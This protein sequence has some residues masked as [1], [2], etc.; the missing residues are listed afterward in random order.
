MY[1]SGAV[2]KGNPEVVASPAG[3]TTSLGT[4]T[5]PDYVITVPGTWKDLLAKVSSNMRKSVRSL[6]NS[7]SGMRI[8]IP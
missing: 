5:L 8:D 3:A 4:E 1:G 2:Y 6:T 7:S